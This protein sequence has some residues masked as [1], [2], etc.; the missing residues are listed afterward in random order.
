MLIKHQ[1]LSV[2]LFIAL[3]MWRSSFAVVWWEDVNQTAQAFIYLFRCCDASIICSVQVKFCVSIHLFACTHVCVCVYQRCAI[4]APC[5]KT[6]GNKE[7]RRSEGDTVEDRWQERKRER[8]RARQEDCFHYL[9]HTEE[10]NH[11]HAT[12]RSH[13]QRLDP[14]CWGICNTQTML[15]FRALLALKIVMLSPFFMCSWI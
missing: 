1:R 4:S 5:S 2:I 9:Q 10:L 6:K 14:V 11:T 12:E 13:S 8:E 3:W 15:Q 7:R